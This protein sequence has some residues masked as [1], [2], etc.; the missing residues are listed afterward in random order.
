MELN[1]NLFNYRN[2]IIGIVENNFDV[3]GHGTVTRT[4]VQ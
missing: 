3:C 4:L 1:K 2:T